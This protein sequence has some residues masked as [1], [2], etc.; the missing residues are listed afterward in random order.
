VYAARRTIAQAAREHAAATPHFVSPYA[1]VAPLPMDRKKPNYDH[2][3][4]WTSGHACRLHEY[5]RARIENA[6]GR[7]SWA[8]LAKATG[9]PKSTLMEQASKPRFSLVTLI[10]IARVLDENVN[11]FL[12]PEMVPRLSN[13]ER[14]VRR[15]ADLVSGTTDVDA[16]HQDDES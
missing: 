7:R 9:P 8:W 4:E 13:H 10:R 14:L 1:T 3:A 16:R 2:D 5:I 11:Y 15:I 12:P 6:L